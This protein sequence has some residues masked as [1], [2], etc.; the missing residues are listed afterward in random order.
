MPARRPT[1]APV[2]GGCPA[3]AVYAWA[4]YWVNPRRINALMGSESTSIPFPFFCYG[5][6]DVNR[7]TNY[8]SSIRM[9][10]STTTV[11]VT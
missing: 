2:R 10:L 8:Q 11:V 4:S 7:L 5:Q 3:R 6:H 1:S 9:L